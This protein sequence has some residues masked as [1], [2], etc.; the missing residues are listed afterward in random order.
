[1]GA[2]RTWG[3]AATAL[4][5]V[6]TLGAVWVGVGAGQ[7]ATAASAA[8]GD[9]YTAYSVT[10]I[11]G[12]PTQVVALTLPQ[13]TYTLTGSASLVYADKATCHV[14]GG[15]SM[16]TPRG[17]GYN[18]ASLSATGVVTLAAAGKVQ[19]LCA[20]EQVLPVP[21]DPHVN[22]RLVATRVA[23]LQDQGHGAP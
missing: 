9:T 5:A 2:R 21:Q 23:S 16:A 12:S 4:A 10:S 3:T 18:E 8:A 6:V 11:G 13:G 22:G 1:M 20:S 7:Q 14:T 17:S 19:L 15:A